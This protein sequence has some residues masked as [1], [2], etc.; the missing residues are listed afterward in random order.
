M[1]ITLLIT[2]LYKVTAKKNIINVQSNNNLDNKF[3]LH[4]IHYI[5]NKKIPYLFII[6]ISVILSIYSGFLDNNWSYD[7]QNYQHVFLDEIS[8]TSNITDL[9]YINF[10]IGYLLLNILIRIF[11]NNPFWLFFIVTFIF[12][13]INLYVIYKL[14]SKY[15]IVVLLFFISYFFFY[16]LY[17]LRQAMAVSF[18]NLAII[19]FLNKK[20]YKFFIYGFI[21]CLF[22]IS[23]IVLLLLL[24]VSKFK[25]KKLYLYGTIGCIILFITFNITLGFI[26]NN[27]SYFGKYAYIIRA[28]NSSTSIEG[29]FTV[30]LKGIPFYILFILAYI[31]YEKLKL[32][33]NNIHIFTFCIWICG[34]SWILSINMMWFFR[35]NLYFL[36]PVLIFIPT[37]IDTI[38]DKNLRNICY[39]LIIGLFS[40][41]IGI[42]M[43]KS[44]Y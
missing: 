9:S 18:S 19:N 10:E 7:R 11:T 27:I 36:L 31:K 1:I 3:K 35:I 5:T 4:N 16:D 42:T 32:L 29:T 41:S 37:L 12:S 30:I 25:S 33:N 44:F 2:Y 15:T 38:K 23:A 13:Y 14:T 17:L 43:F 26:I 40:G 22:H 8:R 24:L 6:L 20:F 34:I 21:A 28:L 39:F